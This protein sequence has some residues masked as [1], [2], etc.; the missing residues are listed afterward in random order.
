MV[1]KEAS[2]ELDNLRKA[3][4]KDLSEHSIEYVDLLAYN[5]SKNHLITKKYY[6]D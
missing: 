3:L 5:R 4:I 2:K 6:E 1:N